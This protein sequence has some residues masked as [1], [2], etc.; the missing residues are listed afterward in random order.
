MHVNTV[1]PRRNEK[2]RLCKI[3]GG[4]KVHYWRCASK[5]RII[6][7]IE[8]A[9]GGGGGSDD[10]KRRL[11][12]VFPFPIVPHTLSFS[13]LGP[14]LQ[15]PGNFSGAK[16]NFKIQTSWLVAHFLAHKPILLPQLV[17]SSYYSQNYWNFALEYKHFKHKTAFRARKV[18]ANKFS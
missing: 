15:R 2:Q 3:L 6:E 10:R 4:N 9:G 18:A 14:F 13:F 7:K 8:G 12:S 1:I 17:V 16:A 11:S 5:C